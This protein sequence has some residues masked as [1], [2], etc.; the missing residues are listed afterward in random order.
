[1]TATGY[2]GVQEWEYTPKYPQE[3]LNYSSDKKGNAPT[4]E[5][6][7]KKEIRLKLTTSFLKLMVER[8]RMIIGNYSIGTAT[9][10]RLLMMAVSVTNLAVK[11]LNLSHP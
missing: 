4:A 7:S 3:W 6:T 9:T 10:Q 1:M 2:I 11:V 5:T 8:K